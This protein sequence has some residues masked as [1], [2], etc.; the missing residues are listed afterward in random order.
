MVSNSFH[1][2]QII[3]SA[4]GDPSDITD[5]VWHAGYRKPEREAKE[6]AAL[7]IDI[8]EGVPDGEPY[9]ARPKNLD[10][11]LSLELKNIVFDTVWDGKATPAGVA[12]IILRCGYQKG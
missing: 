7:T 1:L 12:R 5:A 2:T 4:W 11:I 10:D 9:S 6:I 3:A 8:M